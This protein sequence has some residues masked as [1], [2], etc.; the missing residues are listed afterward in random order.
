MIALLLPVAAAPGWTDKMAAIA[1]VVAAAAALATFVVVI[2]AAVVAWRQ[3]QESQHARYVELIAGWDN[4]WN[5][6]EFREAKIAFSCTKPPDLVEQAEKAVTRGRTAA[7]L[8]KHLIV[9]SVPNYFETIAFLVNQRVVPRDLVERYWGDVFVT[10]WE[11]WR[12]T[13]VFLREH[14][15]P[16]AFRELQV[17]AEKLVETAEGAVTAEA[18]PPSGA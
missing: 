3:L 11:H 12:D 1:A 7:D 13:A 5:A 6:A 10:V 15:G 9:E 2:V 8:K 17:L 18:D 4:D 16:T 14:E